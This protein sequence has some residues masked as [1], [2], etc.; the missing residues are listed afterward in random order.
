M[1]GTL[2]LTDG[3]WIVEVW[4]DLEVTEYPLTPSS[5]IIRRCRVGLEVDFKLIEIEKD[6]TT[7]SWAKLLPEKPIVSDDFQIGPN[8]AFEMT[9]EMV[10]QRMQ[11]IQ[12]LHRQAE[13]SWEG[14]DGCTETDANLWKNGFVAGSLQTEPDWI[15]WDEAYAQYRGVSDLRDFIDWAK[16]NFKISKKN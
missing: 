1:K 7:V 4:K 16:D 12:S 9:N 6:G 3:Q 15:D 10:E 11:K 2:L 13:E 5:L 8:G 14:C